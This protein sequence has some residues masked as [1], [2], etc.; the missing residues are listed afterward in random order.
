MPNWCNNKLHM[1]GPEA[2]TQRFKVQAIGD[3]PWHKEDE[4]NVLNF[5]SLVPIP[6]EVIEAGY[7]K[8]GFDWERTN[9]GCKWGACHVELVDEWEG[10]LIYTFDTPWA[11]PLAF[12]QKL[13]PQ[14]PTLRFVLE[15]EEWGIGYK[16]L[17]KVH[18]DA[19]EDHC[20][21]L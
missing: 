16:G 15:Y 4:P 14:W 20:V 11:P 1:Y 21:N 13:G 7:E 18:G 19:V 17:C 5:H 9:W 10:H 8:A 3:S 12:L 6:A 2:D